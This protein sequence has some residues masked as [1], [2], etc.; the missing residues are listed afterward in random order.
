M[1]ADHLRL[2]AALAALT[3][4]T[5]VNITADWVALEKGGILKT[6]PVT[7]QLRDVT[8]A[9]ALNEIF[10]KLETDGEKP[11]FFIVGGTVAVTTA[12]LAR[13]ASIASVLIDIRP[14]VRKL[15]KASPPRYTPEKSSLFH[16]E[17]AGQS[18]E[19]SAKLK[20]PPPILHLQFAEIV[21]QIISFIVKTI[22]PDSWRDNGGDLGTIKNVGGVIVVTSSRQNIRKI[23][24]ILD[25]W[26]RLL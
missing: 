10:E 26:I 16:S 5:S 7:V 14:L 17:N 11:G 6:T 12:G 22:D 9:K 23:R 13:D 19:A 21:D 20:L 3:K 15:Q 18:P 8:L 25:A 24:S 2:D 1:I 4:A